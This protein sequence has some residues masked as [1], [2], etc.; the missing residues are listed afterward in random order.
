MPEEKR[1]NLTKF[2]TAGGKLGAQREARRSAAATRRFHFTQKRLDS[3]PLPA[4][5]EQRAYYYDAQVPGLALAVSPAGRKTFIIRKKIGGR[6]ERIPIGSY[7]ELSIGF[8][9]NKAQQLIGAIAQGENPADQKRRVRSEWTLGQLFQYWLTEYAQS[10]TKSWAKDENLFKNHL[11]PWR[12][13]RISE[14]RKADVVALHAKIGRTRGRYAANRTVELLCSI[15]NRAIDSWG[16][17]GKNPAA[18]IT[19]FRELKRD[20][21]LEAGELPRFFLALRDEQNEVVRDYI[22]LSLLCGARR[23]NVQSMRWD[24]LHLDRHIWRI[25][26]SKNGESLDVYLPLGEQKILQPRRA[27]AKGGGWVFPGPGRTGHL[28]DPKTAGKGILK[29]A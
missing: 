28:V 24:E 5:G 26:E 10:E 11:H 16:L 7:A 27:N 14:I 20:R 15:F 23:G 13:K 19:A 2:D 9:R 1:R 17:I 22:L 29:R 4:S 8:A 3:V 18:E 25:S 6:S 12:L 21:F